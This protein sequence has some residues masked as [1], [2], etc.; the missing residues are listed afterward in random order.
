MRTL[1]EEGHIRTT[2]V[3]FMDARREQKDGVA[4]ITKAEL[5]N[6]AFVPIPSNREALVLTAKACAQ[7]VAAEPLPQ[8]GTATVGRVPVLP[9]DRLVLD[10]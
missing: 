6:G 7:R 4:H 1:V 2:S 9:I 10:R 3:A 8:D 5:L